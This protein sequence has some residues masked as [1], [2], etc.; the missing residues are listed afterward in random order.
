MTDTKAQSNIDKM[1]AHFRSKIS[2]EMKHITVPEWDDMKI[3]FKEANTLTEESR[4]L[5]LAQQGKTVEALV[6]TLIV[7]ARKED[8]TKM[9]NMHDKVTIMNEVDPSVVIRVCGEMNNN[10]NLEIVEKN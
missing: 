8:G 2:G 6:E 4:L 10:D 3:Y 1:T 9:F 7:K 5:Q